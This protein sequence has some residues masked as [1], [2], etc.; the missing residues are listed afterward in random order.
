MKDLNMQTIKSLSLETAP[1]AS[2]SMLEAVQTKLGGFL[3]NLYASMAHSPAAL[4]AML[5]FGDAM[6]K[7]SLPLTIRE[8]IALAIAEENDCH[9]CRAAHTA[10][11]KNAGLSEECTLKARRGIGTDDKAQAAIDL[12]REI[13]SSRANLNPSSFEKARN[14]GLTDAEILEVL[15]ATVQNIFTNYANHIINTDVDFPA[16]PRMAGCS[17]CNG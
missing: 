9:Y 5:G 15:A 6:N 1:E 11:G 3:P 4:Q 8:Q 16:A 10:I 7:A 13:N 12:A 17:C 14:S 2:K